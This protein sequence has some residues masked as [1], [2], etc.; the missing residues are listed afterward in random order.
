MPQVTAGWRGKGSCRRPGACARRTG[1]G[2]AVPGLRLHRVPVDASRFSRAGVPVLKRPSVKPS[3]RSESDSPRAASSPSRPP[4]SFFSPTCISA[5]RKV[6]G[7]EQHRARRHLRARRPA[8][9]P[10]RAR[11]RPPR[12]TPRP[13][14]TVRL[15]WREEHGLHA[16]RVGVAVAEHA[17]GLHRRALGGVERLE[18]RARQVRRAG[19]LA[20]ERVELAHQVALGGAAHGRVAAHHR[21]AVALERE[22]QRREPHARAGER[23]LAAR[24]AQAHHDDVVALLHAGQL[25]RPAVHCQSETR[26]SATGGVAPSIASHCA[27][28]PP[29]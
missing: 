14:R 10:P 13:R 29:R 18:V 26:T 16:P 3:A 25:P 6:P 17:G 19:H 21:G 7:G 24:M 2:G 28:C 11:P 27:G 12:R 20:A 8:P 22:A 9:R 5:W 4:T 1:R 15:G 23:G